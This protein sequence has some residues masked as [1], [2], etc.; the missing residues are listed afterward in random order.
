M[1]HGI[2][3]DDS[4][5][6]ELIDA[7]DILNKKLS[8]LAQWIKTSKH[9][10]I[11]TGA[12]ISTST[13]IPDFRSGINT[14]LPTGP[15][16][17]ELRDKGVTRSKKA[18]VTTSTKAIPS[19]THM[20]I[21]ELARQGIVKFVISQNIDGLH[22][23]SGIKSSMLAELH[24]NSNLE[25]C[26]KCKT[27]Y[28]RD[29]R[30]RTASKVHNHKTG[31]ICKK[32]NC[33][34]PLLDSIINF[35]E[36]LPERELTTAFQHAEKADLCLVLGSSLRVTPAADIPERVATKGQKLVIGNLQ[37]T[38]MASI[39]KLNTHAMCDDI[40]NGIMDKLGIP[41]P[42]WELHRRIRIVIQSNHIT[43]SGLDLDQ[44]NIPYS[45]FTQV[46]FSLRSGT[47]EV[48]SSKFLKE[49]I[50]H[51]INPM[52][53][54]QPSSILYDLYTE[55]HFQGHYNEPPYTL[56]LP[57]VDQQQDIHL[58]YNPKTRIWRYHLR[59]WELNKHNRKD[60]Y[61]RMGAKSV[62]PVEL[63]AEDIEFISRKSKLDPESV[64]EWYEKLKAACPKG[65]IEKIDTKR[66]L[67]AI[68]HEKEKEETIDKLA[69]EIHRSF[70]TN[71]DGKV[72][73]REFLI[74]FALTSSGSLQER[75]KYVF[76]TYDHNHDGVINKKEIDK[77][78]KV[79]TS[80]HGKHDENT[81]RI[82]EQLRIA[83][84]KLNQEKD[85]DHKDRVTADEFI[86]ILLD[87]KE[88]CDLLSP[89]NVT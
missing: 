21:V 70:D 54:K 66:F 44:E 19:V 50:S 22:L 12:G 80:L 74:G 56:K 10:I 63:S 61:I 4:T 32:S 46:M 6:K 36:P 30:T 77:M 87:N 15:G 78:V 13:G 35:G 86:Q 29:Y 55:M 33:K 64:E 20:A 17:W 5:K 53:I 73:W 84:E 9:F 1:A 3:D 47:S 40:M 14:I 25:Y 59:Y 88:I 43:L 41:I 27:K 69:D 85:A 16:V 65:T 31:R 39:A 34:G 28:L 71:H 68:V 24:G 7:P 51:Q 67:K 2:S 52:L 76:R 42:Q 57:F 58:F 45:L 62:K 79:A 75:L 23:R 60:K 49:P 89:F 8:Q 26:Q 72:D 81:E 18:N 11:F 82:V 48:Y 83:L 38:P 37:L